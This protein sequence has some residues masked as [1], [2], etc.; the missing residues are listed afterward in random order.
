MQ[1]KDYVAEIINK[2]LS[3][4]QLAKRAGCGQATISDLVSGRTQEPRYSLGV[5]L[6]RIGKSQ[7]VKTPRAI[8]PAPAQEASHV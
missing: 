3:Q 6:M 2:G 5:A 1:W 4:S 8:Q 7:G